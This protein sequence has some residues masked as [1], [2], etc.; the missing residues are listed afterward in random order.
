MSKEV[1]RCTDCGNMGVWK[2]LTGRGV[3]CK[4]CSKKDLENEIVNILEKE[5]WTGLELNEI[6]QHVEDHPEIKMSLQVRAKK[7]KIRRI[8]DK[9]PRIGHNTGRTREKRYFPS[10]SKLNCW[11]ISRA[12]REVILHNELLGG[13]SKAED[14]AKNISDKLEFQVESADHVKLLREYGWRYYK[15]DE[16][17]P[18]QDFVL[19]LSKWIHAM[20]M[21]RNWEMKRGFIRKVDPMDHRY[22]HSYNSFSEDIIKGHWLTGTTSDPT[23]F[24]KTTSKAWFENGNQWPNS[25]FGFQGLS[26]LSEIITNISRKIDQIT[27]EEIKSSNVKNE[28]IW[29]KENKISPKKRL[30]N[31]HIFT[32]AILHLNRSLI[33]SINL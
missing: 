13:N 21:G 12:Y 5:S 7:D 23:I 18:E 10:S 11:E 1:R 32:L 20:Q 15:E 9:S 4:L 19:Y 17:T 24:I 6:L 30:S 8:L 33:E 14:I 28:I 31:K 29:L 25:Y 16:L 26:E 22:R 3:L 2:S 27:D